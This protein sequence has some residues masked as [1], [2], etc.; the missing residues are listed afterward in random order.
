[1]VP[2]Q[3]HHVKPESAGGGTIGVRSGAD[4]SV[5]VSETPSG[6]M[7]NG[8]GKDMSGLNSQFATF[9][10]PSKPL[11]ETTAPSRTRSSLLLLNAE[12]S[13]TRVEQAEVGLPPRNVE[14]LRL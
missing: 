9:T 3:G 8:I 7:P 10:G 11:I 6:S 4:A 14:P 13:P 5:T 2:I 1:M 12:K